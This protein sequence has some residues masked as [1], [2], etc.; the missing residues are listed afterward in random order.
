MSNT[1]AEPLLWQRREAIAK[2]RG[3][4]RHLGF[5]EGAS[6]YQWLAQID[7]LGNSV[8]LG[9]L[10][11]GLIEKVEA[12]RVF[13][14]VGFGEQAIAQLDPFLLPHLALEDRFLH[15]GPV[16]RASLGDAAQAA[17]ACPLDG[18]Y[19]ISDQN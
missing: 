19:V 1:D 18:G 16:I 12:Q 9:S 17:A 10:H 5:A 11:S 7:G 3:M 13:S 14:F 4:A 15:A 8:V 6:Q 2:P